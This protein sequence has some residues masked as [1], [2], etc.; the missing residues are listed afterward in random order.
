MRESNGWVTNTGDLL[1]ELKPHVE[2]KT[3]LRDYKFASAI[4][5]NILVYDCERLSE[6]IIDREARREVMAELCRALS[7][8]PGIVALKKM[9]P[10]TSIVD[11]VS[12]VFWQII[13][14][15]RLRGE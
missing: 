5:Q 6:K 10:D 3:Q 4:D 13:Y 8:G 1:S 15:Q 14:E 11:R 12:K 7:I 9:Y 2:V